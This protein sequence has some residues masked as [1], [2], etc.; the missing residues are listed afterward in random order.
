MRKFAARLEAE[1]W[2]VRY[3]RLDDP[4]NTGSIPAELLRAAEATG[5]T[6]VL[7][8][9]PG[10]FRLIAALED[11][12]IP[13]HQFPDDRFLCSHAEFEAWAEGRKSFGWSGSTAR[14]GGRPAS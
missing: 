13:V 4:D 2:R 6:E 7:A 10:E 5:A 11:C 14:C 9:E 12:P 8:T 1:G 3:T